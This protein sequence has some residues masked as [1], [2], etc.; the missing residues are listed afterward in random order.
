MNKELLIDELNPANIL[1]KFV[2]RTRYEDLPSDVVKDSKT[3]ILDTLG[4]GVAGSNGPWVQNLIK[5]VMSWGAGDESR[6]LVHGSRMP[7][8]SAAIINAYQIH[9]LEF[10]CV[11]EDAVLHP[12]ATIMG[13]LVSEID[14]GVQYSGKDLITAVTVGVDA[15]CVLGLSSLSPMR[16]FRPSTA[17]AFGATAAVAKLRGLSSEQIINAFG[18]TYGQ[19]SGTLQPHL[20]GS[21][22]L[23]MQI[24][25]CARAAV[26]ACDL[27]MEG[28]DGPKY[29]I[30]GQYGYLNLFEGEYDH[31]SS[32]SNLGNVWQIS[33]LSHKPFPS[34]RLTHGMVDAVQR[35]KKTN[36]LNP[37]EIKSVR[38]IVPPLAHRLTG[39]PDI[40]DPEPNYAKLCIPFV[41]ATAILHGTVGVNHFKKEWLI[42]KDVHKLAKKIK[43]IESDEKD[44]NVMS[45]QFM[46]IDL[47][48][49][50]KLNIEIPDI[51]GHPNNP[52]SYEEN[53]SKF[54]NAWNS[55]AKKLDPSNAEKLIS[56]IDN[57]EKLED[58][59][60]LIDLL[61][62]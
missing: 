12:M 9:C 30:S 18:A 51:Y 4:V 31:E 23:G 8:T 25:F 53:K 44:P 6:V 41:T 61:V 34:G 60:K 11:N 45:P 56:N 22:V 59:S 14:K 3:F 26:A 43:S 28:L 39:R 58:V 1:S 62:E 52:L 2:F 29:V 19:I 36:S 21:P 16:F 17:G 46:E 24:G 35:L 49:G 5:T 54:L 57:L 13:A 47:K 42:N 27:A 38:C 55:A 37:D 10:D 20:E 33:N 7:A 48:N 32:F 40:E 15:S 50:E